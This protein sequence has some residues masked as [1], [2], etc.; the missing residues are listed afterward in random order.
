MHEQDHELGKRGNSQG[1]RPKD[2][3]VMMARW[4]RKNALL[5]VALVALAGLAALRIS[6]VS[7]ADSLSQS[8]LCSQLKSDAPA[9]AQEHQRR[10]R[11]RLTNEARSTPAAIKTVQFSLQ[12]PIVAT[13][14]HEI[15]A[16]LRVSGVT[17]AYHPFIGDTTFYATAEFKPGEALSDGLATL[18]GNMLGS[19]GHQLATVS[20]EERPKLDTIRERISVH[21]VPI[22]VVFLTGP[23]SA[24]NRISETAIL[25]A[26]GSPP[27][28][29][30]SDGTST[31][32]ILPDDTATIN[33]AKRA[34]E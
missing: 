2:T 4:P 8:E 29:G 24:L 34:C 20:A 22:L 18:Q 19:L 7:R 11:E 14:L 27:V 3:L 28:F 30:I 5:G 23:A 31:P 25:P 1:S 15:K 9:E 13:D 10:N 6:T 33:A 21:D 17:V 26:T 12:R 32:P 16:P